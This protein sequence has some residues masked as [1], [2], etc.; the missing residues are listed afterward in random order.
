MRYFEMMEMARVLAPKAPKNPELEAERQAKVRAAVQK[1][2]SRT[3]KAAQVYSVQ[4][5]SDDDAEREAKKR[6]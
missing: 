5:Q 4:M 6:L 2:R 1:A 3:Q